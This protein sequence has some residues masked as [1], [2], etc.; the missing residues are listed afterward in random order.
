MEDKYKSL[1]KESLQKLY[2]K[3]VDSSKFDDEYCDEFKAFANM[4]ANQTNKT[5]EELFGDIKNLL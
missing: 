4:K 1:L 3:D 2:D 5:T